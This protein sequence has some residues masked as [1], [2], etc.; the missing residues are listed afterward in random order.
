[1]GIDARII[2]RGTPQQE[3]EHIGLLGKLVPADEYAQELAPGATFEVDMGAR[4][5]GPGYERGPW[6]K[7]SAVLMELMATPGV[8]G[9]WYGGDEEVYPMTGKVLE[10]FTRHYLEFGHRP[11]RDGFKQFNPVVR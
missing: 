11:Y 6:P 4:Y 1:M 10:E 9:V 3:L 8:T 7:I 2:I 5:Y